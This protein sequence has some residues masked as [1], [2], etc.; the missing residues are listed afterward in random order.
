MK[1]NAMIV[2]G[3]MSGTSADGIN[4]ALIEILNRSTSSARP[5][6]SQP[7]IR[8]LGHSEFPYSAQ[9]RASI[10]SAM[11]ATAASVADLARLS[12]LLGELYADAVLAAQRRFRVNV[13]LVGCHGQ[14]LYHQGDARPFLGRR[15][16]ATWQTGEAAVIAARVGVPVV[17]D[18]RPADMAAGGKGAPLVPYL[19]YLWFRD[20][21]I[22]RIVQNVGG[23]ANLSA[24]PAG[25][26][27]NDILAFD[28][29]PGNMV[30]DAVTQHL[31]GKSFDRN[32]KIAASGNVIMPVLKRILRGRFFQAKPPKTAG[33]EEFGREFVAAF[34]RACGSARKQDIVASA[35]ALT[36]FSIANAIERFAIPK[37][38]SSFRELI[39][40][41]GGANNATLVS[42]LAERLAPR[43]I[44]IRSSD[45]FG[46]PS[47]AKEAVAFAVLAYE[48][49][50]RRASNVPS[51]TGAKRPAIL[52]KISYA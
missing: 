52:G 5:G 11:N 17:S 21:R 9:V 14:T 22:G 4:V 15:I 6:R 26:R 41:G 37:S 31:F 20:A 43:G 40:S 49:W 2:A 51:A 48:T 46:L 19:D 27:A 23:I 45:E 7:S 16:A 39:L 50:N 34:L 33:R 1:K 18:F 25:A 29:G 30:I 28:T 8:L 32:G 36:A 47:E 44:V 3:V 10:L 13:G 42:M 24:I 38:R 12:F 35:T